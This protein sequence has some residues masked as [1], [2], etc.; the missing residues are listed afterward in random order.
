MIALLVLA[1]ITGYLYFETSQS[2]TKTNTD[3]KQYQTEIAHLQSQVDAL[4][5][6][7][8]AH[9]GS[10]QSGFVAQLS[11]ISNLLESAESS[12]NF[13]NM[14]SLKSQLSSL[15]EQ[16]S[17]IQLVE[18]GCAGSVSVSHG[19]V[20]N[21]TPVLLMQPNTAGSICVTYK[22][23][24]SDDPGSFNSLTSGWESVYLNN[25][26]YSFMM[27]IGNNSA[28]VDFTISS[29]PSS[30]RPSED[31][32]YVTVLYHVSA[33][34]NS[35]GIYEYSAPYGYCDSMPM[36]VGY[37]A[38]QLNGSDF[39]PRPPPHSC[40]AELYA[41]VSV[42]VVGI[43]VTYVDI[44]PS[45]LYLSEDT[46]A[47]SETGPGYSGNVPC[48]TYDRSGAYIFGCTASAATLSGCTVSF[49]T[50][51][52][53]YNVTVWYPATNQSM[54]WANCDYLV[55]NLSG[56]TYRTFEDC[57]PITTNSFIVAEYPSPLA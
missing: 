1:S 33:L 36:A 17:D 55:R 40:I 25:G 14:P 7:A 2:L 45:R 27:D 18:A 47:C 23:A 29:T 35:T 57:I 54:R 39:P 50:G 19:P 8:Q 4:K 26:S 46:G 21:L 12:L 34:A 15:Q 13:T 5:A 16:L 38:S 31:V 10:F 28:N 52:T 6:Q 42:G 20:G 51:S 48:F 37:S 44:A 32:T 53:E 56:Q 22:A 49:G 41:P 11:A 3:V 24:W 43:G 9:N 30:I